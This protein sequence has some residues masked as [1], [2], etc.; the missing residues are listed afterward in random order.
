MTAQLFS[1]LADL[2]N[3][4]HIAYGESASEAGLS[5]TGCTTNCC[6]SYFQHHTYIEWLYVWK[7]MRTLP[8]EKRLHL[9]SMARKAIRDINATLALG[10]LPTVMCP[11]NQDGR[12]VLYPYRL[13]ICRMHGT[14]NSFTLPNGEQR[15]FP[16]CARFTTLYP[17]RTSHEEGQTIPTLDRTPFYQELATLE[18]ALLRTTKKP[19]PRVNLTLAAMIAEGPPRL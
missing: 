12:C 9:T 7:G 3:R 11:L 14:R 8:P 2:Y 15:I 18:I 1:K 10:A 13:M 19:L 4:M 5:C 6:T 17:P 16:G